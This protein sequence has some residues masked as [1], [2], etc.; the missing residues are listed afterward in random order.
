MYRQFEVS[1]LKHIDFLSV[2]L[3]SLSISFGASYWLLLAGQFSHM[4]DFYRRLLILLLIMNGCVAFF[5]ETYHNILKRGMLQEA[6]MS[7]KHTIWIMVFLV[8]YLYLTGQNEEMS[9]KFFVSLLIFSLALMFFLRCGYKRLLRHRIAQKGDKSYQIVVLAESK[10]IR[11]VLQNLEASKNNIA[12]ICIADQDRT[13][14]QFGEIPV[15]SNFSGLLDYIKE[16]V[17]DGIFI[18]LPPELTLPDSFFDRC[19]QMGV[20]THLGLA[21]SDYSDKGQIIERMGGYT[22]LT[23]SVRIASVRQLVVKRLI[24]IC[25]GLA[26]L[27]VTGI[28]FVFVAPLIYKASPGPIFFSQTRIGK[29]GRPFKILKF[30]SMYMDAEERKK[31]LMA[32]N[33]IAD[34]MMFKM[35]DDPRIIKG[36]GHFIRD[37]SIDELPQLINVLKGKMSLVGTRPPTVDEYKK[38]SQHH[39]IRLAI[40]PG[41]TGMWQVSG[42]SNITDFEQVVAL[43]AKYITEWSLGLD[44]KILFKTIKVVLMREGAS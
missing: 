10:N 12:G 20:S 36:I 44:I 28:C 30:R 15:V 37:Y 2:D 40:K 25:A 41:I 27:I 23:R 32:Q 42:R 3:L 17:V 5:D 11:Q 29:N 19:I 43:D 24:D 39:K 38:Y 26:G 18:D 31:E 34:G 1:W 9:R 35:D 7:L 16:N 8:L 13:G 4:P 14:E 22:V 33:K 6:K 21:V